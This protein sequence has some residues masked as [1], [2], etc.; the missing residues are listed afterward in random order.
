MFCLQLA[1]S[2][3][4]FSQGCATKYTVQSNDYQGYQGEINQHTCLIQATK[5]RVFQILTHEEAFREI[6]PEGTIVAFETPPPYGVGTLVKTKIAH[7]FELE[8]NARVEEVLRDSKIRLRFLD[9]FFAGGT[10]IWELRSL[11]E[12]TQVTHTVI[13]QHKGFLSRLAWALKVRTKHNKMVESF[14]DNLKK[15]SELHPTG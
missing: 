13:V 14:L 8:W 1:F 4:L 11:G 3:F 9:G 7:I 12:Q 2:L 10:E 15:V 5:D 6:C